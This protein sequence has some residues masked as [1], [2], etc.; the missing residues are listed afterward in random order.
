MVDVSMT[1]PIVDNAVAGGGG[2]GPGLTMA[3]GGGGPGSMMPGGGILA[4]APAGGI[5]GAPPAG[6]PRIVVLT[7]TQILYSD[8]S[9]ATWVASTGLPVGATHRAIVNDT[10]NNRIF[11]F[12]QVPVADM[13]CYVSTDRGASFALAGGINNA[14]VFPVGV[15]FEPATPRMVPAGAPNAGRLLYPWQ[16]NAPP[17]ARQYV[18]RS[19]D[20]AGTW[21]TTQLVPTFG[22]PA[23]ATAVP[24][25][26]ITPNGNV[27]SFA[28]DAPGRVRNMRSLDQGVTFTDIG[29]AFGFIGANWMWPLPTNNLL[30]FNSAATRLYRGTDMGAFVLWAQVLLATAGSPAILSDGALSCLLGL[31]RTGPNQLDLYS[32][33]DVGAT[34]V[35]PFQTIGLGGSPGPANDRAPWLDA[36]GTFNWLV[37]YDDLTG[38][39]APW[40]VYQNNVLGAGF[41]QLGASLAAGSTRILQTIT[42]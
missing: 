40:T 29:N 26:A 3:F 35:G 28:H 15:T 32:S 18:S 36:I 31:F 24:P 33:G 5:G 22:V 38:V 41:A 17:F 2:G 37:S 4:G 7:R 27:Y 10:I 19:D 13:R 12:M 1:D 21:N 8:T 6:G 25:V 14:A 23:V 42:V 9:G 30:C 20:G 11:A 16:D 34:W 39:G